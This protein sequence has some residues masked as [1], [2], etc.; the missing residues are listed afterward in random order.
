MRPSAPT[1]AENAGPV[2]GRLGRPSFHPTVGWPLLR[3]RERPIGDIDAR[4]RI[5]SGVH[6]IPLHR[7]TTNLVS[8]PC[9]RSDTVAPSH[10]TTSW[11]ADSRARP[12]PTPDGPSLFVALGASSPGRSARSSRT[13]AASYGRG[14]LRGGV[15][16]PRRPAPDRAHRRGDPRGRRGRRDRRGRP[17]TRCAQ[18]AG[19]NGRAPCCSLGRC[20][21]ARSA[22]L[23]DRSHRIGVAARSEI[24][25][26]TRMERRGKD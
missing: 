22:S 3:V 25:R 26:R 10:V 16:R 15:R 7:E 9:R 6:P 21:G 20:Q 4:S 13:R 11:G 8:Q 5:R 23:V 18:R 14:D 1:G 24:A 17:R 2:E 19:W 12:I